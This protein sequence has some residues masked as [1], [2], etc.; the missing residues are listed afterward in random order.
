MAGCLT[1]GL[2]GWWVVPTL[3]LTAEG[4]VHAFG[5]AR[6]YGPAAGAAT[7]QP[8]DSNT[9]STINAGSTSGADPASISAL[10]PS[11]GTAGGGDIV[12]ISGSGFTRV[13]TVDFGNNASSDFA[14]T[15]DTTISAVAPVG[16]GTVIVQVVTPEGTSTPSA[17]ARFT[18][19]STGQLPITARGQTFE[20]GGLPTKFTGLNAYEL[21][22]DWGTNA[23]CGSMATPAQIDAFFGSLPRHSIVRFWAFQGAFATNVNTGLLDWQPLDNVF[24]AAAKYHVYLIP[25]ISDQAGTCDGGTWQDPEWYSGGF[26]N[27]YNSAANS[28]GRGLTPLSYWDYMNALVSRYANSPALGMWEPM[29]EAEASTCPAAFEPSNCSGHQTCPDEAAAASALEY[30]FTTVGERIHLLDTKHLV[31]GGLL[32]GSQCGTAAS[33]YRS[34]G[35]SPGIDVLSV[36]DYYGSVPLGGD[37]LNGMA[38]RFAQ[39]KALGKPIITGEAGIVAG[40]DQS[41]CESLQQRAADMSAKMTA[42]FADGDGA[43][44]V[45]DWVVDPLGPCSY[46]TGPGDSAL[47]SALES[48]PSG[49]V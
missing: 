18:Y 40:E 38:E 4:A 16:A 13:S 48:T 9:S 28:D 44:L 26:A 33:Y 10:T 37:Q 29:S 39:A 3:A 34:V 14:I 46:N 6:D 15:S 17:A 21:A 42:Q 11:S 36:H 7:P 2:V 1:L 47:L 45:W 41:G 35:S 12:Q 32:G 23:G 20:I 31:E 43:F 27:V 19:V 25:A 8:S 22:T 5:N 49:G 30:F 24:Y